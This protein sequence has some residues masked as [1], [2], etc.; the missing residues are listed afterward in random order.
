MSC[1]IAGA[2][3]M[4]VASSL[5]VGQLP[6]T[7]FPISTFFSFAIKV[8]L[9]HFGKFRS[10]ERHYLWKSSIIRWTKQERLVHLDS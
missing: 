2:Q 1:D 10:H 6:W 5:W 8:I 3:S 4:P 9:A 7:L